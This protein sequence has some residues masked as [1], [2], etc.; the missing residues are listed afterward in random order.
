MFL[1]CYPLFIVCRWSQ[2]QAAAYEGGGV[3]LRWWTNTNGGKKKYL[4]KLFLQ[5]AKNA[6]CD[7]GGLVRW[8]CNRKNIY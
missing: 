6:S 8:G 5:A 1:F 2:T 4:V 7:C 3:G